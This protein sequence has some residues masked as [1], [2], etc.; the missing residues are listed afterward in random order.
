MTSLSTYQKLLDQVGVNNL[1]AGNKAVYQIVKE[2]SSDF[3][4]P[5]GWKELVEADPEDIG[6]AYEMHVK[7]LEQIADKA[8]PAPAKKKVAKERKP[9]KVAA[10]AV[11]KEKVKKAAAPKKKAKKVA[12]AKVK[13][14]A[15]KKVAKKEG[16]KFPITKKVLSK[17]LQLIKRMVGMDG[18][19]KTINAL[20]LFHRDL[21][22]IMNGNPSKDRKP[23]LDDI[24]SRM[25][26]AI[27][28]AK[29]NSATEIDVKLDKEFKDR[30]VANASVTRPQMQIQYLAGVDGVEKK[31]TNRKKKK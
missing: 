12:K 16:V 15:A 2:G 24:H 19:R 31:K 21:D 6:Q 3:T 23:V 28:K 14:V 8:E 26:A 11:K 13:K 29:S 18:K 25:T 7:A 5:A 27:D 1:S 22:R 4:D 9:K 20:T 17:E 30:L 10:P